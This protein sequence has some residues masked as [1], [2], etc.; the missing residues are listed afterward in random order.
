MRIILLY[1]CIK[2]P[3]TAR[4]SSSA[5]FR[6]SPQTENQQRYMK[7]RIKERIL[8]NVERKDTRNF[9][10]FLFPKVPASENSLTNR[11]GIYTRTLL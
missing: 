2:I 1:V 5:N 7:E 11:T 9:R 6:I 8:I 3:K 4:H 10:P